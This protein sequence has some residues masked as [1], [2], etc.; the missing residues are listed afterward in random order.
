ME[1][2]SD[3]IV[4]W[5]WTDNEKKPSL[6]VVEKIKHLIVAKESLIPHCPYVESLEIY[7]L[8]EEYKESIEAHPSIT[9]LHIC[10]C[11]FKNL[12]LSTLTNIKRLTIDFLSK[13]YSNITPF[14]VVLP[15]NVS[16][17]CIPPELFSFLKQI[18]SSLISLQLDPMTTMVDWQKEL[19]LIDV[20]TLAI[21]TI[22]HLQTLI[23]TT[24][25]TQIYTKIISAL[26]KHRWG[27][28][29][30]H[31]EIGLHV[32]SHEHFQ[33]LAQTT[34]SLKVF[35]IYLYDIP[36]F[37]V[38]T[39]ESVAKGILKKIYCATMGLKKYI[40]TENGKLIFGLKP[41]LHLF[42]EVHIFHYNFHLTHA[43]DVDNIDEVVHSKL[44]KISITFAH[45]RQKHMEV[46]QKIVKKYPSVHSIVL[47]ASNIPIHEIFCLLPKGFQYKMKKVNKLS[48]AFLFLTKK[49]FWTPQKYPVLSNEMQ[50]VIQTIFMGITRCR[51]SDS[52]LQSGI[53]SDALEFAFEGLDISCDRPTLF[54][55]KRYV[56]ELK[57]ELLFKKPYSVV[58]YE[59]VRGTDM[60]HFKA[61]CVQYFLP[62]EYLY[63]ANPTF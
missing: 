1:I 31:L 59:D 4:L 2:Q 19:F 33:I 14:E 48:F 29:F 23:M 32:V 21:E 24:M 36:T 6:E 7:G 56:Y 60:L 5:K 52:K 22:P 37:W 45:F 17:L 41:L 13:D 25:I 11:D 12:D 54:P 35:M 58:F 38:S 44:Q 30:L 50:K 10:V 47:S 63:F 40:E 27:K 55:K 62:L 26:R 49:M 9:K 8:S 28:P 20:F 3:D 15:P 51:K 18:P 34:H 57:D 61:S 43:F 53:L 16:H 39:Y 46:L 42:Q